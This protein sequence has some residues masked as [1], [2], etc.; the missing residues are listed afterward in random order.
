MFRKLSTS[1]DAV[2]TT[3]FVYVKFFHFSNFK[4]HHLAIVCENSAVNT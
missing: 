2:Y 4:G 1:N 3:I